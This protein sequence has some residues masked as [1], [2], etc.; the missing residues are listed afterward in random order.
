MQIHSCHLGSYYV[1]STTKDGVCVDI[2]GNTGQFS[3]KYKDFFSKIHIY[4]PQK[5]CLEIIKRNTYSLSNITVFDEAVF[6]TSELYV[7]LLS[8]HNFDSGSVAVDSDI[9]NVKEWKEDTIVDNFC[10]TISLEDIIE[11]V[12]GYIDYMKVD[13]ETS[14][15]NLFIDKDL[16]K[17]KYLGIKLHWQIGKEN[18]DRLVSHI[19]KY[20]NN[21]T[22]ISLDYPDGYNIEVFFESKNI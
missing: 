16:S 15:Y 21:K 11:R 13:C 6:H 19:L 8:H 22:D 14:E 1:P 10:K 5:E 2:G 9:I 18:F 20:F 7:N 4:E 12:G 17:I 3:L